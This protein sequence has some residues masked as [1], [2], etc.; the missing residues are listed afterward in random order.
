MT[1]QVMATVVDGALKL[2]SPLEL[3]N[4]TRVKLVVEVEL[5]DEER[6]ERSRQSFESL[7]KFIGEHPINS[8][9]LRFTRDELYDRN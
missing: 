2:D 6:H 3:P 5:T 4:E 9:G 1:T 7:Q 8:G